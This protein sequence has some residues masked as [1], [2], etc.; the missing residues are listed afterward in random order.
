MGK[1]DNL[2]DSF[3]DNNSL[4]S[5]FTSSS[6]NDEDALYTKTGKFENDAP[7]ENSSSVSVSQTS[8]P[9]DTKLNV[10]ETSNTEQKVSE[11]PDTT[12]G[13]SDAAGQ[14]VSI[15]E[16]DFTYNPSTGNYSDKDGNV[17]SAFDLNKAILANNA[18]VDNN[19]RNG[20]G[21]RSESIDSSTT[22]TRG[23]SI[24]YR[25]YDGTPQAQLEQEAYDSLGG[26]EGVHGQQRLMEKL[27]GTSEEAKAKRDQ[28][29][30]NIERRRQQHNLLEGLR[31]VSDIFSAGFGGNVY[32]R[33]APD[34]KQYDREA[35]IKENV[36]QNAL[37]NL[38]K[39]EAADRGAFRT[40]LQN[41]KNAHYRDITSNDSTQVKNGQSFTA[42]LKEQG[43]RSSVNVFNGSG[44]DKDGKAIT[45]NFAVRQS[46]GSKL[47][48]HF[49][50]GSNDV[51]YNR[52][53]N[54]GQ[55]VARLDLSNDNVKDAYRS[56]INTIVNRP[57][58]VG[59]IFKGSNY[60]NFMKT[61]YASN[62]L[63]TRKDENG[64]EYPVDRRNTGRIQE[65]AVENILGDSRLVN[66]INAYL[67]SSSNQIIYAGGM[68]GYNEQTADI[69]K[70]LLHDVIYY[71]PDL[72]NE[73]DPNK[74]ELEYKSK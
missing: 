33:N 65:N 37:N 14:K 25:Q 68:K 43:P 45:G 31:V 12:S 4:S 21:S 35:E 2:F 7:A 29:L 11:T 57:D 19:P 55:A 69:C 66:A 44:G 58:W 52:L 40:M 64:N 54:L 3:E 10:P 51:F 56:I 38:Y 63:G 9:S 22:Q 61:A 5:G 27:F 26:D 24:K 15:G 36:Y 50:Y 13:T 60:D 73:L 32:R 6:N 28:A 47:D 41:V 67:S 70:A 18:K 16:E 49:N 23:G 30:K 72:A 42:A 71:C 17:Y 46:D 34:Y 8:A 53:S 39:A 59:K 20:L 48:L 74:S 62:G 1:Y